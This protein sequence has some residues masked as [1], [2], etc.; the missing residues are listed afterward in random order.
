MK[1]FTN[2]PVSLLL[3]VCVGGLAIASCGIFELFGERDSNPTT[4]C[5]ELIPTATPTPTPTPK[6]TPTPRRTPTPQPTP[7][8]SLTPT[9]TITITPPPTPTPTLTP[10][11]TITPTPTLTVT[12]TPTLTPTPMVYTI[13]SSESYYMGYTCSGGSIS[14]LGMV[15][16]T[17]G[18]NQSFVVTTNWIY[19]GDCSSVNVYIDGS[20][21]PVYSGSGPYTY[22]FSNVTDNHT[23][24]A[25]FSYF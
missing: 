9:P 8:H 5:I 20:G 16:V 6:P 11:P 1:K 15:S 23:I 18:D 25:E 19:T 17:E 4:P 14:P 3:A 2:Y 24:N 7:T 21:T 22:T 13:S 12:P 10:T